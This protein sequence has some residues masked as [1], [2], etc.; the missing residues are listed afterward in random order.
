MLVSRK[1]LSL[2][3]LF[4]AEA[5]PRLHLLQAFH[6]SVELLRA[7]ALCRE[8]FQPIADHTMERLM[9]GFGQQAHLLDQLLIRTEG[10]I[11]HTQIVHTAFVLT[12]RPE[13]LAVSQ[14]RRLRRYPAEMCRDVRAG[15]AL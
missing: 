15:A 3:H 7:A 13:A 2:I 4:A 12:T 9:P 8:L 6:Q 14:D 11:P 10:H 1:N 5:P